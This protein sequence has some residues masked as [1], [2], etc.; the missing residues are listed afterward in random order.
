[1]ETFEVKLRKN[2]KGLGVT[3]AGYVDG[4]KSSGI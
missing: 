2:E 1:M 4:D 3:I